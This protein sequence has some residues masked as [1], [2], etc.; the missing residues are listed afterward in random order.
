[1][2]P[3]LSMGA[4]IAGPLWPDSTSQQRTAGIEATVGIADHPTM[5]PSLGIRWPD[6][7]F[8]DQGHRSNFIAAIA[9]GVAVAP[10]Q[11]QKTLIVRFQPA[12]RLGAVSRSIRS[13]RASLPAWRSSTS[14][15]GLHR[16]ADG[17][18]HANRTNTT[19][20]VNQSVDSTVEPARGSAGA[21][22]QR[23]PTETRHFQ[24]FV[25]AKPT[26]E[27]TR[28]EAQSNDAD[29]STGADQQDL[30][31]HRDSRRNAVD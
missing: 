26:N 13:S 1:M 20:R 6:L 2:S 3:C 29:H 19:S 21:G 17:K 14:M 5:A 23:Q 9:Q 22:P 7:R 24:S 16:G 11:H 25:L 31:T 15:L 12:T 18:P 8:D 28:R 10:L 4:G 27:Q 30:I